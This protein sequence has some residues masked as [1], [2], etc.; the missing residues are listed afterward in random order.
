MAPGK[1]GESVVTFDP[2]DDGGA[3]AD[4]LVIESNDADTPTLQV[5]VLAADVTIPEAGT[6][7]VL[8][9]PGF[10]AGPRNSHDGTSPQNLSD[11]AP[12]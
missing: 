4:V 2:G 8:T 9:N 12:D 5:P 1:T 11:S 10:E 7:L 3:F 6:P